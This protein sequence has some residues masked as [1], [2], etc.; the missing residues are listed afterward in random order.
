MRTEV[1]NF[2]KLVNDRGE[3]SLSE[4]AKVL[5]VS[6]DVVEE[7][8]RTLDAA[9]L[10]ELDYPLNPLESPRVKKKGFKKPVR[11]PKRKAK[12]RKKGGKEGSLT[13]HVWRK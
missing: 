2:H 8:A 4:A 1:H 7:W 13:K 3:I 11:K 9:D 5:K 6:E 10:V 12:P